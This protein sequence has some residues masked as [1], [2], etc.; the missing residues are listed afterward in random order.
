MSMIK[1]RL[2]S[3]FQSRPSDFISGE[4]AARQLGCSRAAIWKHVKELQEE[5]FDIEAVNRKGYRLKHV[6]N[7]LSENTLLAGLETD[8]FGQH[9][10]V[11]Q[12]LP[13]TQT[14]LHEL[15][16]QGAKEGTA[17]ICDQQTNGRGRL[18]RSWYGGEGGNIAVSMLLRPNIPLQQ[19]TQLT[20]VMAV[21]C[22][23]AIEEVAGVYCQIKWPNDLLLNGKKLAG[24]L[25]ETVA[26]PDQVVAAIVGIGINVNQS[27]KEWPLELSEKAT[28]LF[29]EEGKRF[30]RNALLQQLFLEVERLYKLYKKEGF[31]V[32]RLLWEARAETIGK[33]VQLEGLQGYVTGLSSDGALVIKDECGQSHS[34]Y[35]TDIGE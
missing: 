25:T 12:A 23:E 28:S 31:T 6:P 29:C 22:A 2:F 18:Q 5:G 16:Q 30:D 10:Y 14:K 26:E 3:L 11:Y 15:A 4:E 33:Y 20:L 17:V 13:S 32:I 7:A 19:A 8:T 21:A 34:V 35:I 1:K 24:I 9:L 27:C